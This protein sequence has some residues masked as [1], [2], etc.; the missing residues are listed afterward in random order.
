MIS[1]AL[2]A[3]LSLTAPELPPLPPIKREPQ[4]VYVDRAGAV[5]GVRGG[6]Y[7]PPVDITKLPAH[8]PAAFIAIE[9]RRFYEHTGFDAIGIA[10][11]IVANA[12][13]GRAAQ[14][15]ST[16]T[17]QLARNLFL[18]ADQTMERKAKEVM[19]SVQLERTYSKKQILGLYL[20]RVYFGSGAY[21]IEQASRRY[22]G[23]SAAKLSL[24]EAATLAG[25][26]KSPTKYN[27]IEE[28]ANAAARA[29]LVLAA[30][31]ETGAIT[32]AQRKQAMAQPLKLAGGSYSASANY[33]IDWLDGQRRQLV[34]APKQDVIVET[35]LDAGLEAA[36]ASTTRAV[37]ERYKAQD[38]SQAALV[39]LD[40][41]GRVRAM[42][43]GTDYAAAPYNRAV[44]AKRQAGSAWKPFVYLTALEAGRTPDMAVVDE[45]ITIG[46]WSP[47]NYSNSFSGTLTLEQAVA[48]STNT[49]AVRLADE[50][51]RGN[52]A[53]TAKRLGV[54]SVV[55]TDPAMALGTSLVSPLEMAQA[56]G[57]FSNG[58]NR[59]QAYGIERIRTVGGQVLY[60]RKAAS[61]ANV[62][63]NPALSDLNRMLR[64]VVAAGTGTR[65]KIPG[66]DIAGKTGTT[67]DYKDAWFAGYSGGFTTVVWMGNDN[68]APMKRVTGGGAPAELWRGFMTTALK[69]GP[70]LAIPYGP[71][72]AA[73]PPPPPETIETL[74]EPSPEPAPT[75][76]T[77]EVIDEPPI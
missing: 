5:L 55:N 2:A 3:S 22:F 48:Q 75:T 61:A 34:G 39:A 36:A 42:V 14:G 10:R 44:T 18:S 53:A 25:V 68:G 4:V 63:G 50:V 69:R 12:E 73:P 60:Q 20:S 13:Q 67:S 1:L 59:V 17:Q 37:V 76:T 58:G 45:P 72:A 7:G 19:Y 62:I 31:V 70:A 24:R 8:V 57:A 74:L 66:Y 49:V 33:F 41:Q 26:L 16:I 32:P 52:V 29:D 38:V 21:G 28:P 11:A 65:A 54:V 15:A 71:P 43:G 46:T 9:D 47:Q 35:T 40:G 51:G 64:G 56:Y 77:A 30:M 27:P 6:R 23:K